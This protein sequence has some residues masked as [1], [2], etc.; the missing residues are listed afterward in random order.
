M[1]EVI[2]KIN[3]GEKLNSILTSIKNEKLDWKS[4]YLKD[5]IF[6]EDEQDNFIVNPFE[7]EDG[8]LECKCGSKRVYSYAKQTRGGDEMTTTFAECMQCKKKWVYSG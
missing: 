7:V 3:S 8:V 6:E 4:D 5:Y 2:N 1:Y